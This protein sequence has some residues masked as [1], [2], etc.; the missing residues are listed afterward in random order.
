MIYTRLISIAL[1]NLLIHKGEFCLKEK[2]ANLENSLYFPRDKFCISEFL[3]EGW[4]CF[5]HLSIHFFIHIFIH[6]ANINFKF[7]HGWIKK[8]KYSVLMFSP[9]NFYISPLI[10]LNVDKRQSVKDLWNPLF[11]FP[12]WNALIA[13]YRLIKNWKTKNVNLHLEFRHKLSKNIGGS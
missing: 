3:F 8:M 9:F 11:I 12:L 6:S 10:Y 13:N 7:L 1:I 4:A 2:D 5:N